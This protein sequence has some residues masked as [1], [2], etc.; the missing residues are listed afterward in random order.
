MHVIKKFLNSIKKINMEL[1][2][3]QKSFFA[4]TFF[5]SSA[6]PISLFFFLLSI[7]SSIYKDKI[8]KINKYNFLL[9]ICS[10]LM[11]ISTIK[12]FNSFAFLSSIDFQ[13]KHRIIIDLLNWIPLF[14]FFLVSQTYLRTKKNRILFGQ[15]LISGST[16]VLISCVLQYFFN[17]YGPFETLNG[18]IIWFQKERVYSGVTGL[19]N[20]QNYTGVWLTAFLPFLITEFENSNKNK[21]EKIFLTLFLLLT[22]FFIFLTSSRNAYLGLFISFFIFYAIRYFF[23][24]PLI[25]IIPIFSFQILNNSNLKS[26]LPENNLF[27]DKI[28]DTLNFA[29]YSL[30]R[31]EGYKIAIRGI[32]EKPLLGLG[33][34]T[35]PYFYN[36]QGGQWGVQH[37]HSMPLELAFNYGLPTS[38]LLSFFVLILLIN[39]YKK[40]YRIFLKNIFTIDKAWIVSS[41]IVVTSHIF[42]VTYYEGKI[43]ILIWILLAG[44][45]CIIDDKSYQKSHIN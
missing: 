36:Y 30:S 38:I 37:S 9:F 44:L 41:L 8:Y 1:P 17:I 10:G 6:L 11:I 4:G 45:K 32:L 28:L 42:D 5:L 35:Y 13:D 2:F 27:V 16:P 20:N 14:V 22:V 21:V 43:S 3:G 31:L 24:I 18:L 40:I 23:I 33:A 7:V 39:A 26:Y 15:I 19:F 29:P 34:K 12:S 25:S